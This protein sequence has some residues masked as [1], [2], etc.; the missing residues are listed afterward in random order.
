MSYFSL[1][2]TWLSLVE[3]PENKNEENPGQDFSY[4]FVPTAGWTSTP[5]LFESEA[6]H[7]TEET[8]QLEVMRDLR[9]RLFFHHGEREF[10]PSLLLDTL[11][12]ARAQNDTEEA[13]IWYCRARQVAQNLVEIQGEPEYIM[14]WIE[15]DRTL[16][17]LQAARGNDESSAMF[18][19]EGLDIIKRNRFGSDREARIT[20]LTVRLFRILGR[21]R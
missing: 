10:G 12:L 20:E 13:V 18:A 3:S 5:E 19:Q 2:S 21:D 7:T 6:V 15:I 14:A 16:A 4:D 8:Q 11:R 9:H 17:E 1:R